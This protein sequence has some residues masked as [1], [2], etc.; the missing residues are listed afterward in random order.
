MRCL[1]S[2]YE[3][4][5]NLSFDQSSEYCNGPGFIALVNNWTWVLCRGIWLNPVH[6]SF[7]IMI[8]LKNTVFFYCF[9]PY[10]ATVVQMYNIKPSFYLWS[11]FIKRNIETAMAVSTSGGGRFGIKGN[12]KERE[13]M[14]IGVADP[15]PNH[16]DLLLFCRIQSI[17]FCELFCIQTLDTVSCL[18]RGVIR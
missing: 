9:D 2:E 4:F 3:L 13:W 12:V 14:S 11:L 1:G 10:I 17:L 5:R 18:L 8:L 16:L 15:D 7:V 6:G